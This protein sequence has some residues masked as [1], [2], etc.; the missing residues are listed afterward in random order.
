MMS[1]SKPRQA[2]EWSAIIIEIIVYHDQF[3]YI[4]CPDEVGANIRALQGEFDEFLRNLEGNHPFRQYHEFIEN[5]QVVLQGY[6]NVF[7]A[8]EFIDWLNVVRFK[9]EV[10]KVIPK[11]YEPPAATIYF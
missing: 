3:T 11:P 10:A 6:V 7:G 1:L 4:D 8:E 9:R 5:G 2:K